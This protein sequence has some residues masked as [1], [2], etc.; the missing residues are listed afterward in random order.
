M[1]TRTLVEDRMSFS[2]KTMARGARGVDIPMILTVTA[3]AVVGLIMLYSAS[4]DFSFSEYGSSTY[5]FV[6]QVKWLGLGIVVAFVLSR[7]DYHHWRRFV[8]LAMLVTIVLLL[9]VLIVNEIRLGASRSLFE[10]SYQPSEISKLITVIY[11]SVWLYAKRQFLHDI[12][13]GLIP[14]GV[15]LGIVGG[16]IYL[17]PDLSAAGT[18]LILGGVLFFLAGA[19]IRQ[20]ILILVAAVLVGWAVVQ[21]SATGQDRV[22]SFVAGLQDPMTASYHVQRSLEAVIKGGIFGV[23]LGQ[24]DTKLTGLPF[25]PTD[26]IFAVVVEELGLFGAVLL[27]T[28][29]GTLV[30]RGLV[31]ARRAPD[32]LGT[33]L[34]SGITFW[35]GIEALINMAVMVGLL[36]FAGNALPFVSA[37]GSNLVS[38]LCS[39]G[40]MLNISR[41]SGKSVR[42]EE[43]DW[44]SFGAVIDLRRRNGRRRVSRPRRS[45]RTNG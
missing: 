2:S 20:I 29:Y 3:L 12:K 18:V 19:N 42:K 44:R 13:L 32:M 14:L 1:G 21:F 23:G 7:F 30:W 9:A 27:I 33:L 8:L 39:I 24:A 36:P 31:I 16:L 35:I 37:G 34:A 25:A 26:S 22:N 5:M 45:R 11:L 41:Q 38:M 43:N 28:L 17:Q 6:R 10:G 4:F 40:I 15:I